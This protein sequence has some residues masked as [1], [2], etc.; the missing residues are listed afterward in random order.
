MMNKTSKPGSQPPMGSPHALLPSVAEQP[1]E[2]CLEGG[3]AT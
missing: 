3:R 2:L 1:E